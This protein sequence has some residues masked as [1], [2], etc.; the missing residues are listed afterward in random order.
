MN[1]NSIFKIGFSEIKEALVY[2]EQWLFMA[3][4]D[5][6]LRYRRS[7][8]GPWWVTIST[9]VMVMM[10]GFLWS[11]IFGADIATYLP[12]FAIGFVIWNWISSQLID[13]AGGF[14]Q[15]QG[16][17]KQT[18][19]AFP[20]FTLR[21][22]AKQF[23]VLMHNI[24]IIVLVL[25]FVGKGFCWT[26]LIAIPNLL[27]IQLNLALLSVVIT[28]FCTR[29]QDISQVVNIAI[30]IIFFFT[31]I[32]WQVNTL[33][34]RMYLAEWNPFYHWIEMIRAPL[35][36]NLPSMNDY[37]WSCGSV[38]FLFLMATYFLGRYRTRIAYWL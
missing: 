35:L 14:F 32:L 20:V 37:L 26:N 25:L 28:I 9:G 8:I 34:D 30:Q 12:F 31:P 6:K 11:H 18:R 7:V 23:I 1:F 10:L 17:I 36:G 33:K 27:L 38:I 15:F 16:L 2:H 24:V 21:L 4:Q 22:N 13:A 29:Y 3:T 19:I 5:I